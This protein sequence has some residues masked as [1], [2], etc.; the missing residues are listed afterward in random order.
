MIHIDFYKKLYCIVYHKFLTTMCLPNF[1]LFFSSKL[2]HVSVVIMPMDDG[3]SDPYFRCQLWICFAWAY[4]AK[5]LPFFPLFLETDMNNTYP[6]IMQLEFFD[7]GA[8]WVPS[9]Y[10]TLITTTTGNNSFDRYN[11]CEWF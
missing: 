7:L 10:P 9:I 4:L 11:Y 1:T 6:Y 2:Y 5:M 3:F 8:F